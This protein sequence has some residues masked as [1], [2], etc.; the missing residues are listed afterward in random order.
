MTLSPEQR[1]IPPNF[2]YEAFR[3]PENIALTLRLAPHADAS[4]LPE[5]EQLDQLIHDSNGLIIESTTT[6]QQSVVQAYRH[7]R[8]RTLTDV[9]QGV[10]DGRNKD[11]ETITGTNLTGASGQDTWMVGLARAMYNSRLPIVAIDIPHDHP[12][13]LEYQAATNALMM[14]RA[15]KYS[16]QIVQTQMAR[17]YAAMQGRDQMLLHN[18]TPSL[19]DTIAKHRVASAKRAHDP[20]DIHMFYGTAH[21]SLLDAL[22]HKTAQEPVEGFSI[23]LDE[24]S[25]TSLNEEMYAQYLR[26]MAIPESAILKWMASNMIEVYLGETSRLPARSRR[27][28]IGAMVAERVIESYADMADTVRAAANDPRLERN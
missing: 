15:P 3:L 1:S 13:S 25:T 18:L 2:D 14:T 23:K 12:Y 9:L 19:D 17:R 7:G 16:P 21:R 10:S 22:S 4:D 5:R 11:Y 28:A 27:Q 8:Q 20:L 26:G 6:R 24:S